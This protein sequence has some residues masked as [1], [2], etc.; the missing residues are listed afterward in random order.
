MPFIPALVFGE[1]LCATALG[2]VIEAEQQVRVP[3]HIVGLQ[4]QGAPVR[5]LGFVKTTEFLENRSQ[6]GNPAVLRGRQLLG[7]LGRLF[8]LYQPTAANEHS[9]EITVSRGRRRIEQTSLGER[10]NRA[11]E[12]LKRHLGIA[13]IDKDI[14]AFR[15]EAARLLERGSRLV[16]L[17]KS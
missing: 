6:I 7:S 3:A 13:D 12:L 16:E 2:M 9:T 5:G 15:S 8:G 14:S 4:R 17:A 11:I 10:F 1:D